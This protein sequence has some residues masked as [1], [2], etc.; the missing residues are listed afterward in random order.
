[1]DTGGGV[2]AGCRANECSAQLDS[3]QRAFIIEK[4]TNGLTCMHACTSLNERGKNVRTSQAIYIYIYIFMK[5]ERFETMESTAYQNRALLL[6]GWRLSEK[7]EKGNL[8]V[9]QD[10]DRQVFFLAPRFRTHYCLL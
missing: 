1:M 2:R 10:T 3:T 5:E 4:S 7:G 8:S 9:F 6:D